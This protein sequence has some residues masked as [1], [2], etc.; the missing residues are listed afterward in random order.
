[1]KIAIDGP[2]AAGKSTLAKELAKKLN[3]EYLDT[4]AMY[5]TLALYFC[6]K[7]FKDFDNKKS[8]ENFLSKVKIDVRDNKFYLFDKDVSEDIRSEEIGLLAS[9]ISSYQVI[10]KFLVEKQQE[11]AEGKD[12]VMDGRDVGTV[13][14]KNA[15]FK[16]YLN[17]DV[18]K[19]AQRRHKDLLLK[20]ENAD[21][22]KTLE[23][24]KKRDYDDINREY[25]PLTKAIDAVEID[26]SNL[27][28]EET[29]DEFLKVIRGTNYV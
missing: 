12:I 6:E 9:K 23:D 11:I 29:I 27:S 5:R 25:S 18:I 1:M 21:F 7:N 2:S 4:G 24:L 22:S 20:D 26:T 28:L 13:I 17:A 15:D 8:L 3:I 10:R 14:L 19:R 16:F